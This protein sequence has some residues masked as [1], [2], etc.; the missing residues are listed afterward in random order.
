MALKSPSGSGG[1]FETEVC[2]DDFHIVPKIPVRRDNVHCLDLLAFTLV[3]VVAVA[4]FPFQLS[5]ICRARCTAAAAAAVVDVAATA[6]AHRNRK[7]SR[8]RKQ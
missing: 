7:L 5:L 8:A 6:V 3:V 1:G 2:A 4:A